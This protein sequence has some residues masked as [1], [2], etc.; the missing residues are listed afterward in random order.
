MANTTFQ[1]VL[2]DMM[3]AGTGVLEDA[4]NPEVS[5]SVSGEE[6]LDSSQETESEFYESSADVSGVAAEGDTVSSF[7]EWES[8]NP[9]CILCLSL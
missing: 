9:V 7:S 6:S 1:S 8:A 4:R 2:D 5:T 3:N